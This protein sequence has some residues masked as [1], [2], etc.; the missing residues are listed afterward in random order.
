[1]FGILFFVSLATKIINL[2]LGIIFRNRE[3]CPFCNCK[4]S[5]K[6]I[7]TNNGYKKVCDKC[8]YSIEVDDIK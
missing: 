1:M 5:I 2:F 6:I 4:K 8:K 7:K 3:D